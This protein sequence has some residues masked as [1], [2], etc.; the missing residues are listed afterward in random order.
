MTSPVTEIEQKKV[1]LR[2]ETLLRRNAIPSATRVLHS[3]DILQRLFEQAF[4]A[5]ARWIEFYVSYGSEVETTGMIAHA[6]AHGKRVAVPKVEGPGRMILSEVLNPVRELEP[7]WRGIR[8][9]KAEF[10]RPVPVGE[11]DA[12]VVPGTAFDEKGGRIGKGIGF[13]DRFLA[14]AAGRIPI[15]GV[16]FET[17]L[18]PDIPVFPHDIP[19]DWIITEKRVIDCKGNRGS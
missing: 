3:A 2:E 19:V 9:P 8:E 4:V 1:R 11:M 16:A 5:G 13:Y 7:G 12:L 15:V 18:V 10:V 14:Q 17:Q 6:L